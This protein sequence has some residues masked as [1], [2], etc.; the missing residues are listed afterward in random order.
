MSFVFL[1]ACE[2]KPFIFG[3][4]AVETCI[5]YIERWRI[6]VSQP[7]YVIRQTDV[8]IYRYY[9]RPTQ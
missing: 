6:Q 2:G 9:Y 1:Y 8:F 4:E 7:G 5:L 3:L